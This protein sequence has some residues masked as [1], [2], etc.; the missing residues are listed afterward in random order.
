MN[1]YQKLVKANAE[2]FVDEQL[3]E[4][5]TQET[6]LK[7]YN[8]LDY[9]D[10]DSVKQWL[11]VVSGNIAKDYLKKGGQYEIQSADPKD[12]LDQMELCTESAESCAQ[13]EEIKKAARELC[14][15]ACNLLYEKNPNWYEVIVDSCILGM[16]TQQIAK[17]MK[18]SPR[19]VDAMKFRARTYLRKMLGKDYEELT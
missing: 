14:R 6:F 17:V 3:A 12:M 18:I 8:L 4:D 15:T 5:V 9:L 10:D 11:I 2:N 13:K 7:M 1:L 16:S 19:N